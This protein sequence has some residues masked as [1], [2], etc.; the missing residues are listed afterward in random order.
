MGAYWP[1]QKRTRPQ[2]IFWYV[3]DLLRILAKGLTQT[4]NKQVLSRSN[5]IHILG[6]P[7]WQQMAST[8]DAA[9]KT[10]RDP[11]QDG[12]QTSLMYSYPLPSSDISGI[13]VSLAADPPTKFEPM[14]NQAKVLLAFLL[15][16]YIPWLFA[17]ISYLLGRLPDGM[18]NNA[19]K[20][21][22][23]RT[24]T[25]PSHRCKSLRKGIVVFSDQQ[26]LTGIAILAAGFAT[27]STLN[28]FDFQ[29]IIYL[30]W[31][32]SNVHLST[33]THLREY[34]Q[35]SP[36]LRTLR[37]VGMMTLLI[38]LYMALVATISFSWAANTVARNICA[39]AE[40]CALLQ[41]RAQDFWFSTSRY[42]GTFN[43]SPQ[44]VISYVLLTLTYISK[45]ILLFN[46]SSR[47]CNHY[48]RR[49]PLSC[50][51]R[52]I[53]CQYNNQATAQSQNRFR[54]MFKL[55]YRCALA[56]VYIFYLALSDLITSFA[57]SLSILLV[58]LVWGSLQLFI[59][60]SQLPSCVS[61]VLNGW[62]YGQILPL[63]FLALPLFAI[64]NHSYGNHSSQVNSRRH[65][66]S[67]YYSSKRGQLPV[68]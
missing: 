65:G 55:L 48:L 3:E 49:A 2:R 21:F 24:Q 68:A 63:I 60:R 51:E 30:A 59:P 28:I 36:T 45:V 32:S 50:L 47:K 58:G 62:S 18:L 37:F 43:V 40:Y 12:D 27:V 13:G 20:L 46:A 26:I 15:S 41:F 61:V 42:N 16:A 8:I 54:R 5:D 66:L 56:A 64:M 29:N 67:N 57:M 17:F 31:M 53:Q 39:S 11:G 34:F 7:C 38:M 6:L 52:L 9:S 44:S 19:D 35:A 1:H 25:L 22:F 10:C 14:T 4:S 23:G 33:L